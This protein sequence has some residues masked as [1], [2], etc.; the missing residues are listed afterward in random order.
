M[1][2]VGN[3]DLIYNIE[4]AGYIFREKRYPYITINKKLSKKL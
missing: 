3:H 1:K 2:R 4:T